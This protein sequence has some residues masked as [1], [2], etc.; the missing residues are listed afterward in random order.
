M[1][2][3]AKPP[4]QA[5]HLPGSRHELHEPQAPAED[6]IGRPFNIVRPSFSTTMRSMT[7]ERFSRRPCE[8]VPKF[9]N[10]CSCRWVQRVAATQA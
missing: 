6:V 10:V 4:F 7:A 9:A 2:V 1:G 5:H 8:A 3:A